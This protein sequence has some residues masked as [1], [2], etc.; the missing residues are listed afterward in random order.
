[1]PL[2]EID[3]ESLSTQSHVRDVNFSGLVPLANLSEGNHQHLAWVP[4]LQQTAKLQEEVPSNYTRPSVGDSIVPI[5]HSVGNTFGVPDVWDNVFHI[6]QNNAAWPTNGQN[7]AN[8]NSAVYSS[9]FHS[10]ASLRSNSESSMFDTMNS[11][12]TPAVTFSSSSSEFQELVSAST[13]EV[14]WNAWKSEMD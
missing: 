13:E 11:L 7:T 12:V 8:C 4:R 2:P 1:V 6:T 14:G 3:S 5:D 10:V 9:P